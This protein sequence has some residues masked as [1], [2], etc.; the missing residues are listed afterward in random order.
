MLK[1]MTIGS[2]V[3]GAFGLAAGLLVLLLVLA[4]TSLYS[5]TDAVGTFAT[6]RMPNLR[7]VATINEAQ[8]DVARAVYGLA[9]EEI[10]GEPRSELYAE[11]QGAFKRM[12]EGW[13]AFDQRPKAPRTAELFGALKEPWAA[14]RRAAEQA[15]ALEKE[16]DGKGSPGSPAYQA[17]T[18][19]LQDALL[20]HR[21]A[22]RSADRAIEELQ[23][24]TNDLATGEGEKAAAQGRAATVLLPAALPSMCGSGEVAQGQDAAESVAL[25]QPIGGIVFA[26]DDALVQHFGSLLRV[27]CRLAKH[28]FRQGTERSLEHLLLAFQ[29]PRLRDG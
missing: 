9:N 2:K 7:D 23:R 11:A 5:L 8:T 25:D 20:A 12:D 14:W 24:W 3:L 4:V 22:Y 28:L 10:Q 18:K 15:L 29:R 21:D 16:R 17:A 26:G 27:R 13:T 19:P 6:A 1:K